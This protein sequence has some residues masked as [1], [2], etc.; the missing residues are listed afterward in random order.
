MTI[1]MMTIIIMIIIMITIT[2][3]TATSTRMIIMIAMYESS[4]QKIVWIVIPIIFPFLGVILLSLF[5]FFFFFFSYFSNFIIFYSFLIHPLLL[6]FLSLFH[7]PL[8]LLNH[9][10]PSFFSRTTFTSS[11]LSPPY[12]PFFSS[13]SFSSS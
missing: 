6:G 12:S 7:L 5:F 9:Q 4:I 3:T 8:I 1:I 10:S 11:S 13:T 2:T